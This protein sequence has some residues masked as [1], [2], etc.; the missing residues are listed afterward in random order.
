[1]AESRLSNFSK[2]KHIFV[3]NDAE[4]I[5]SG[6]SETKDAPKKTKISRLAGRGSAWW[7]T[8]DLS[9]AERLWALTL[10]SAIPY[11]DD[12]HWEQVPD[13]PPPSVAEASLQRLHEHRWCN[14]SAESLP[15]PDPRP[16]QSPDHVSARHI[17]PAWDTAD[18]SPG[19]EVCVDA[20]SDKDQSSKEREEEEGLKGGGEEKMETSA[21]V[22]DRNPG[23]KKEGAREE[24]KGTKDDVN[25]KCSEVLRSCPMCLQVFPVSFSQMDCDGHLAQCLSD[26]NVDM[27]W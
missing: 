3:Q 25:V 19:Q 10:R 1:M 5:P 7:N 18:S 15:F 9:A 6:F 12:Q 23:E 14:L 17:Q 13:L 8:K 4:I 20:S 16:P 2:R 26:M 24:L 27:A 11:L 21:K 22:S